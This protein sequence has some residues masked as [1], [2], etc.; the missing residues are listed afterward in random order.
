[1]AAPKPYDQRKRFAYKNGQ[2]VQNYNTEKTGIVVDV[3]YPEGAGI[4]CWV[5]VMW[6]SGKIGPHQ[7]TRKYRLL[8][9]NT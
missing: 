2:L 8:D 5:A 9:K 3:Q 1:M 6:D 7:P 4:W